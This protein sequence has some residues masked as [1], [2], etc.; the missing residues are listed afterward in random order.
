MVDRGY[1]YNNDCLFCLSIS[2]ES[3]FLDCCLEALHRK[4]SRLSTM[5]PVTPLRQQQQ[6]T[7]STAK[8]AT[9][10]P[11]RQRHGLSVKAGYSSSRAAANSQLVTPQKSQHQ[12]G[13][14]VKDSLAPPARISSRKRAATEAS[15]DD[16]R[17]GEALR[18]DSD[19]IKNGRALF[20]ATTTALGAPA[21]ISN[22]RRRTADHNNIKDPS[23]LVT[24]NKTASSA[25][26][27]TRKAAVGGSD[28]IL[29]VSR[30]GISVRKR[31]STGKQSSREAQRTKDNERRS[32]QEQEAVEW[33]QKYSKAF[34]TF[35]FYFDGFEDSKKREV[36]RYVREIG[37]VRAIPQSNQEPSLKESCCLKSRKSSDSFPKRSPM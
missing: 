36:E 26:E 14:A 17:Q 24:P 2:S 32:L 30:E 1:L 19:L 33:K 9:G 31:G 34:K 10:G 27:G 3:T 37:A 29:V 25:T 8:K 5:A 20:A 23:L 11:S 35:T 16:A 18:E 6:Q 12:R 28:T 22:K 21:E 7:A 15:V 4:S 13:A